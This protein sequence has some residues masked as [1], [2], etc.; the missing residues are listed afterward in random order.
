MNRK[1]VRPTQDVQHTRFTRGENVRIALRNMVFRRGFQKQWSD[2]I[3]EVEKV[4]QSYTPFAYILKDLG[5]EQLEGKFFADQL[6]AVYLPNNVK[7]EEALKTSKSEGIDWSMIK[8]AIYHKPIWIPKS[9]IKRTAHKRSGTKKPIAFTYFISKRNF[10][11][12]LKE[13][14]MRIDISEDRN[15]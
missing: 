10:F 13:E 4:N 9:E 2:E 14:M 1:R 6:Q 11:D 15:V 7:I 3:F 12:S 8:T 5:G